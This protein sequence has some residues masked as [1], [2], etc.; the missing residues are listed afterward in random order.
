MKLIDDDEIEFST[1]RRFYAHGQCFSINDNMEV[2]FGSDGGFC[3]LDA[4]DKSI[5]P[6]RE[7]MKELADFNIKR[8]E[9][10]R[11]ALGGG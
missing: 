10:F 5:G 7:E 6:T 1:G 2:G 11:G 9:A 4:A 8:W 3:S